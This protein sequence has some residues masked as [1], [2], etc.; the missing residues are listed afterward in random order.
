LALANLEASWNL[1]VAD[2]LAA[3]RVTDANASFFALEDRYN[4]SGSNAQTELH[5]PR[6]ALARPI[7]YYVTMPAFYEDRD[8]WREASK[9]FFAFEAQATNFAANYVLSGN[10]A[11]ARC[12]I[13]LLS[14]WADR[15]ALLAFDYD[16][17]HGQAWYAI[18]WTTATAGLAYSV[19]RAEPSLSKADRR[20]IEAWL[21]SVVTKHISYP[22]NRT[23]CCNNHLYWR[24]LGAAIIGVVTEDDDLFHFG[25]AA[26][27]AALQSM[28]PDGSLPL[29]VAR[30][31]RALHYQN[32]A[33]LPLIFIAE[34]AARQGYDLYSLE[35]EGRQIHLA[36]G[37]LLNALDNPKSLQRYAETKQDT[38]FVDRG[39]EL[40]WL[41]PY[42]RRFPSHTTGRWLNRLRPLSHTWSG[43]PS[44]L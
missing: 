9:P 17:N 8:G 6:H 3:Y 19:V 21:S 34:V 18:Q 10:P 30:G 12:L 43:G 26:Y 37:F 1:A 35:I 40:N 4:Q 14:A 41:E 2:D 15:H 27:R 32:F 33:I 7:D 29:E 38:S 22:G 39:E 28:N 20:K 44:T 13:A 24:G 42:H 11:Y 23:S 16:G 5:C 31:A 36:V 25:I